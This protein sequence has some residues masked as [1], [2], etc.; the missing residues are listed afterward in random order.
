[1]KTKLHKFQWLRDKEK[2][3]TGNIKV[4]KDWLAQNV[5]RFEKH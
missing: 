4:Y 2:K 1:M 3:K 5:A